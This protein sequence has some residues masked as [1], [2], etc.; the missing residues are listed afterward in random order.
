MSTKIHNIQWYLWVLALV[1]QVGG[2]HSS[3]SSEVLYNTNLLAYEANMYIF[4]SYFLN[5]G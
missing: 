2:C 3:E 1:P 5:F 4:T